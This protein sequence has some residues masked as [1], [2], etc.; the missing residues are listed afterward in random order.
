MS[1][2]LKRMTADEFLLWAE[3][4]EG[5]WELHDGAPVMMSPERALHAE[6]KAEA[7]VALRDAIRLEGCD[8]ECLARWRRFGSTRGSPTNLMPPMSCGPRPPA[9]ALAVDD[10]IVVVEV[11][12]PNTAS[13]DHG[14]KLSGYFSPAERRALSHSRSGAAGR[15]SPQTRPRRCDRDAGPLGR[16]REAR[17]ARLRGCGRGAVPRSDAPPR[18]KGQLRT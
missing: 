3:G 7:Y 13:I 12:S 8:V 4:K 5:R 14:R 10:P 2:A 17:S 1:T 16:R 6:T 9:D 11:L 18:L 15:H